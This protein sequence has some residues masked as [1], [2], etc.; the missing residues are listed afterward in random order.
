MEEYVKTESLL[1]KIIVGN[2]PACGTQLI[3]VMNNYAI[4]AFCN[5]KYKA[6]ELKNKIDHI[7]SIGK[8]LIDCQEV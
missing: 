3:S 7:I 6:Y 5:E 1:I 4:C 8:K 2:C